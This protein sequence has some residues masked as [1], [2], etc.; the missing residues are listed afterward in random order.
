MR[1]YALLHIAYAYRDCVDQCT[2]CEQLKFYGSLAVFLNALFYV[3]VRYQPI[4]VYIQFTHAQGG[5]SISAS[6]EATLTHHSAA[7]VVV[8]TRLSLHFTAKWQNEI[9][10]FYLASY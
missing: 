9:S 8:S 3:A 1:V 4:R 5:R 10:E 2:S 6:A 7:V